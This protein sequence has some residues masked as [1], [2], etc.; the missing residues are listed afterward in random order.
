MLPGRPRG[1]KDRGY[2]ARSMLVRAR[3][4]WVTDRPVLPKQV[5]SRLR[6]EASVRSQTSR[7]LGAP[8]Y[9]RPL[10]G[11]PPRYGRA[12]SPKLLHVATL[13]LERPLAV[14]RP[15]EERRYELPRSG[16]SYIWRGQSSGDD[17]ALI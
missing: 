12:I 7:R 13:R 8:E 11:C 6:A 2:P 16:A 15:T 10:K 14:A 5:P 3:P 9:V 17:I 1:Q 4:G